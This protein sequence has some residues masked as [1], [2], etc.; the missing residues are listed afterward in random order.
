M[1]S[2]IFKIV[3]IVLVLQTEQNSNWSV[4]FPLGQLSRRS[5]SLRVCIRVQY[6]TEKGVFRAVESHTV[7]LRVNSFILVKSLSLSLLNVVQ[8]E[9]KT[10]ISYLV[11]SRSVAI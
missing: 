5:V 3:R 2:W 4:H 1:L 7:H 8:Q 6:R 11:I 10:K 9:K